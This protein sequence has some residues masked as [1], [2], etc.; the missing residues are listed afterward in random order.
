MIRPSKS[1]PAYL[2][3]GVVDMRKSIDGLAGIVENELERNPLE[4]AL[5]VF[6]NRGRDKI[7]ILYWENNGFVLWYKRLEKQRFKWLDYLSTNP[8]TISGRD[9][10]RLLDG[11]NI[12][13]GKPHEALFYEDMN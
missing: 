2:Y 3:S 13:T 9:L 8:C 6:C 4:P 11:L 10:N 5:F 7:K 12:F 1:T